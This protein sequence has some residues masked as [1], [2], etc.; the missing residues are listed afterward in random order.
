MHIIRVTDSQTEKAFLQFPAQLYENKPQWVA[1]SEQE[2]K[3]IF[4]FRQKILFE[5]GQAERWILTNFRGKMIGRI[6]AFTHQ[7]FSERFEQPTGGIGL[8]ECIDHQKAAF[9][10][11]DQCKEWLIRKGMKAML[12][13]V[14]L[15]DPTFKSGL[16]TS[17]FSKIPVYNRPYHQEYYQDMFENYGFSVLFKQYNYAV[18]IQE[19]GKTPEVDVLADIVL[20]DPE[21]KIETV[22]KQDHEGF[23][24]KLRDVY[25]DVW[26]DQPYFFP[27]QEEASLGL[28]KKL[29]QVMD[30]HMVYFAYHNEQPIGFM[31]NLPEQEQISDDTQEQVTMMRR[32]KHL[33]GNK[34]MKI[35]T[36]M[37]GVK[38][39]L[40]G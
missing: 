23:A 28:V 15:L 29:R 38:K 40:S 27:L 31:I 9:S 35:T 6:A 4:D 3:N 16:L 7:N 19:D 5:E 30:E 2:I 18:D 13:P 33:F 14:D 32:L 21:Y 34:H 24:K 1:T 26:Q 10:L 22:S 25:N 11:F 36:L 17:G 39:S 8:F 20:L 12:G 37:M